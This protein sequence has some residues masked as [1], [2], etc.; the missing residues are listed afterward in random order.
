MYSFLPLFY[1]RKK[2]RTMEE[3]FLR[4]PHLSENIFGSLNNE[5]LAKSKEVCQSWYDYLDNQNFLEIRANKV[6]LVIETVE[7]LEN[8][9]KDYQPD[10]Q[11]QEK[12]F[13]VETKKAM[14]DDA[15]NGNF[16]LVHEKI[17][18]NLIL[19]YYPMNAFLDAAI[20]G[21]FVV[22]KYLVDKA[23][24]EFEKNPFI[25]ASYKVTPLHIAS[26]H[27]RIEIVKY[28][29]SN[30][31]DVNPKDWNGDTPLHYAARG[32]KPNMNGNKL[33]VVQYIMEKLEDN[34][35]KNHTGK[36]PLHVAAANGQLDIFKYII[37]N[38]FEKN[39][40]D[41]NGNTPLELARKGKY[42]EIVTLASKYLNTE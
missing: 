39:P 7:R 37:E 14:I 4:F 6:K 20:C 32:N 8:V 26:V 30:I 41:V 38:V 31:T 19:L 3:V 25:D 29:T 24:S 12:S 5:F 15:R 23:L 21:H 1:F 27:G 22:V 11:L 2:T 10:W 16:D 34:C 28:I 36:T 17:L 13:S 18:Q 35:P 9:A 33:E 40:E 42:W